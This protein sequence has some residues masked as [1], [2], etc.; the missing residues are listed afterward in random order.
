MTYY[1]MAQRTCGMRDERL[2]PSVMVD[3]LEC[4]DNYFLTLSITD[5]SRL[6]RRSPYLQLNSLR[7]TWCC[8]VSPCRL[9]NCKLTHQQPILFAIT[10]YD[11]H[12]KPRNR[13]QSVMHCVQTPVIF[14]AG[15]ECT[16]S[17]GHDARSLLCVVSVIVYQQ[18]QQS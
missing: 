12:R 4:R 1:R 14:S 8:V 7:R 6:G 5:G 16:T 11:R 18:E 13:I 17:H 3:A 15:A 9:C 10:I 2:C